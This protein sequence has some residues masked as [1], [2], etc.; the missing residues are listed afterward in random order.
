MY[1]TKDQAVRQTAM[2]WWN[3]LFI[4]TRSQLTRQYY[5]G[6]HWTSLTSSEIEKMYVEEWIKE[7]NTVN[8]N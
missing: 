4:S 2:N 6:R 7:E 8:Q 5:C 3:V 1:L